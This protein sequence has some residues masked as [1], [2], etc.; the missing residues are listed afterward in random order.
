MRKLGF[1]RTTTI[2][3]SLLGSVMLLALLATAALLLWANPLAGGAPAL[4]TPVAWTALPT[5]RVV[6]PQW[7][8]YTFAGQ[9]NDVA[10]RDNLLWAATEG[11]VVAWDLR[12]GESVKFTTEH[13]LAANRTTTIAV[14]LDGRIWVGTAAGVSRYDGQAWQTFTAADG[15]A[16]DATTDLLVDRDG[17]VWAAAAQGL[18]RYDGRAW[19]SYTSDALLAPLPDGAVRALA[20]AP[21]NH[22][23]LATDRGVSVGDGR[24]W[25]SYTMANDLLSD[26]VTAVAVDAAGNVWAGSEVGINRFDGS[27]WESFPLPAALA[28]WAPQTIAPLPDGALWLGFG[29]NAQGVVRFTPTGVRT[30]TTADGLS[31]N[32]VYAARSDGRGVWLGT[33][34]GVSYFDGDAWQTLTPPSDLPSATVYELLSLDGALWAAT[35][36][37]IGR[38][39]GAWQTIDS[40]DGLAADDVRALAQ[41]DAGTL[42]A[43]HANPLLGL[44]YRGADGA[45]QTLTCRL[46]APPSRSVSAGAL[47]PDGTVWF[48]TDNGLAHFDGRQWGHLTTADGLPD[49]HVNALAIAADGRVWAGTDRGL[50]RG[51]AGAWRM[52]TPEPVTQLALSPAGAVWVVSN[53]RIAQLTDDALQFVPAP[54]DTVVRAIVAT[55]DALWAATPDGA[56]RFD[57]RGWR[58]YTTDDGLPSSDVTA[59]A[60]DAAGHV[61]AS[62]SVGG[63]AV[64]FAI[65]DGERWRPHPNRR[66]QAE[67]LVYNIVRDVLPTPD[68]IWVA[69]AHGL[70]RLANGAWTGYSDDLFP[71]AV[72]DVRQLAFADD[73]VWLGTDQGLAMFDGREWAI[74]GGMHGQMSPGISAMAVA[75][76]GSL[77]LA[78]EN[79]SGGLRVYDGENWRIVPTLRG[80]SQLAAMA[81][82]ANGRLWATGERLDTRELFFGYYDATA[83]GWVW[84]LPGTQPFPVSVM[85]FAPDGRLWLGAADGQGLVVRDVDPGGAVDAGGALGEIVATHTTPAAP[86]ALAFGP[87]GRVWVGSEGQLYA[88]DGRSWSIMDVPL[89]FLSHIS[90]IKIAPD[91]S[92]W[93]GTD[94]GA[95]WLHEDTWEVFYAPPQSPPWWGSVRAMQVRD[96]GG[97]LLG[98]TAGGVA[99]Y[100]GRGFQGARPPEWSGRTLPITTIFND[101]ENRLWIGTEGAGVARLDGLRWD[102]IA[103]SP[104]LTASLTGLGFTSDGTAWLGTAAGIV[105]VARDG[106]DACRYADVTEGVSAVTVQAAADGTLWFG[107]AGQ[108]ALHQVGNGTEAEVSWPGAPIEVVARAPDGNLWF[109]N[110]RQ[111]WLSYTSGAGMRRV[112]LNRST[113]TADEITALAIARNL[114]V[115]LGT[116]RGAVRTN[117]RDWQQL[118]TADGLADNRVGA[119]LVAPDGALWFATPGGLSRYRP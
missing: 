56:A 36:E 6:R 75:P 22:L 105:S 113:V 2:I 27:R 95:A 39:D 3:L 89:P 98:T 119:L 111:D 94:Q 99:I 21:D 82:D 7:T 83:G 33:G 96:D 57:D 10:L 87:D 110:A 19:R 8:S 118:T 52:V 112:P 104:A 24:S 28:G 42:W 62:S 5:P 31:D 85:A 69:T 55:D 40:A 73:S 32:Q 53:G 30:F 43:A 115:W 14:G 114:D 93:V 65:F 9:V 80:E 91:G 79:F 63:E 84:Q 107:T 1:S 46:D 101:D 38:F 49:N 20:L 64:D 97:V 67:K 71:N 58:F 108:G 34:R 17:V 81:F 47:A 70:S 23:W 102:T 41:D 15:L 76:D 54:G 88:W 60:R 103:P 68:G 48:A 90:A 116:E 25:Q 106:A 66:P 26:D 37:G 117:G 50:A 44:S 74:F 61:W 45:W 109:V 92:L 12:S 13:G 11:G 72:P 18:S 35:A 78:A 29:N 59:V 4:G 16:G 77:W 51:E 100:T 86:S